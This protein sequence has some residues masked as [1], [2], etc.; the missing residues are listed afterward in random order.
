[1]AWPRIRQRYARTLRWADGSC[2]GDAFARLLRAGPDSSS[3]KRTR[4]A[5]SRPCDERAADRQ[6]RADLPLRR[7]KGHRRAV[8]PPAI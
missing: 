6:L 8:N 4:C 7:R 1:M 3:A 5:L 2:P